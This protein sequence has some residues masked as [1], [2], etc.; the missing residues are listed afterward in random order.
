MTSTSDI[1]SDCSA[2]TEDDGRSLPISKLENKMVHMRVGY[3]HLP[4]RF[5]ESRF[6]EHINSAFLDFHAL[7]YSG[8]V[9]ADGSCRG[10][11]ARWNYSLAENSLASES[12]RWGSGSGRCQSFYCF[13]DCQRTFLCSVAATWDISIFIA[14]DCS[15]IAE[16]LCLEFLNHLLSAF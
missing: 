13:R 10:S 2:S 1:D 3:R 9:T 14:T 15:W 4:E 6:C 16:F 5:R 8:V 7:P 12:V 11:G